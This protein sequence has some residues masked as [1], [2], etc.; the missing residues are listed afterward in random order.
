MLSGFFSPPRFQRG[1]IGT[2]FQTNKKNELRI[3]PISRICIISAYRIKIIVGQA[4]FLSLKKAPDNYR[5]LEG[6]ETQ[7]LLLFFSG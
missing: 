4:T 7:K 3:T 2:L 6:R 1:V 5:D